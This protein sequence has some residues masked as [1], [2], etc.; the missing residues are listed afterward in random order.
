MQCGP[1]PGIPAADHQQVA[2]DRSGRPRVLGSRDVEPHRAEDAW[3]KGTFDQS[4]IDMGIKHRLHIADTT[5]YV[6]IAA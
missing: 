4:G 6:R 3:R 5:G 2:N 1:Q